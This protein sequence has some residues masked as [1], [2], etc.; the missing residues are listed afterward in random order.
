MPPC[1]N[2]SV[3]LL[4]RRPVVVV[5]RGV[6][7]EGGGARRSERCDDLVVQ[8]GVVVLQREGLLGPLRDELGRD[9]GLAA[10]RVDGDRGPR[11]VEQAHHPQAGTR[12]G[13]R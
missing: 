12:P 6:V 1:F 2:A 3:V 5:G 13:W 7:G 9:G 8:G 11:H 4:H 10:Q